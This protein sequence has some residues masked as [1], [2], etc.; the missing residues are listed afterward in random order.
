[1]IRDDLI[2]R[3]HDCYILAVEIAWGGWGPL[4][5]EVRVN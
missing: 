4:A 1:M 5:R 3:A 2:H